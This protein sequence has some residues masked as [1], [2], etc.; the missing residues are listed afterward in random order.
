MVLDKDDFRRAIKMA[1][2]FARES[3]NIVK[4]DIGEN[5]L[6][7]S[8]NSPQVGETKSRLEA[9]VAGQAQKIAFNFRF[10][11]DLIEA[12]EEGALVMELNDSL[13][14]AL[15]SFPKNSSFA[16]VIMPVRLQEEE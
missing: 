8:A 2:I 10:L 14:P 5:E 13:S 15:F 1:A 7:I 9:Q 3:A 4:L 16:H 11:L 12:G 6:V